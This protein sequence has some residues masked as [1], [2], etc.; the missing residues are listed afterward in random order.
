MSNLVYLK[1][2][3]PE[4]A[5]RLGVPDLPVPV[6]EERLPEVMREG[7]I[8]TDALLDELELFLAANPEYRAKYADFAGR[9]AYVTG[10]DLG[11][12]GLMEAAAHYLKIGLN[13]DPSNLSLRLNRA[14][15][16]QMTGRNEE[17]LAEYLRSL[18]EADAGLSPVV[19]VLAA[20]CCRDLGRWK[21][22]AELLRSLVPLAPR[23]PEFWDF[24][25]EMEEKAG[26]VPAAAAAPL[27]AASPVLPPVI[28][29]AVAF[30][31]QCGAK[32]EGGLRFCTNCGAKMDG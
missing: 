7:Q 20:R 22:G 30:C 10:L 29:P 3:K 11:A 32:I 18:A 4:L 15:A 28:A 6:R 2:A 17:A 9:L 12:M 1:L 8:N 21:T 5:A 16:L 26:L 31:T 24:L 25:A 19:T 23:E 14:V 13:S 27:P